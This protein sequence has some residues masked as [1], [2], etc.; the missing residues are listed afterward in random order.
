[1]LAVVA[2]DKYRVSTLASSSSSIHAGLESFKLLG[3][4]YVFGIVCVR[5]PTCVRA[6]AH[7]G[8][9]LDIPC[10]VCIVGHAHVVTGGSWCR[11]AVQISGTQCSRW[12]RCIRQAALSIASFRWATSR[13]C[14]S[15]GLRWTRLAGPGRVIAHAERCVIFRRT[16]TKVFNVFIQQSLHRSSLLEDPAC[17]TKVVLPGG[18]AFG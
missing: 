12:Q 8:R 7:F 6:C 15:R 18:T 5:A 16:H 4:R 10:K 11:S 3:K 2:W 1:M 9:P 17:G 13:R 14:G